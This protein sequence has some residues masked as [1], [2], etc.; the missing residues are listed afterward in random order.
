MKLFSIQL[1]NARYI[2][3]FQGSYRTFGIRKNM[4][5]LCNEKSNE[6]GKAVRVQDSVFT[7]RY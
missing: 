3:R 4:H 7:Q 2:G 5:T 6:K 1:L